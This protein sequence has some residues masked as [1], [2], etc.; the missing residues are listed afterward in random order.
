MWQQCKLDPERAALLQALDFETG[1]EALITA[2]WEQRF[3]QLVEWQ[4]CHVRL[5]PIACDKLA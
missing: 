5:A 1:E 4:S 3:D 2:E